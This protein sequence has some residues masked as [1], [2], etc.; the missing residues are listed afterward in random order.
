MSLHGE[1]GAAWRRRQRDMS[2]RASQWP[3]PQ[4]PTTA[5]T[6]WRLAR[7][8]TPYGDRRRTW[9]AERWR[10]ASCATRRGARSLLHQGRGLHFWLRCGGRR[11]SGG[12]RGSATSW[13]STPWCRWRNSWWKSFR[14]LWSTSHPR[15]PCLGRQRQW[16]SLLH[17]FQQWF[18]A[19][20]PTVEYLAPAPAVSESPAPVVE[21]ISPASAGLFP[22][23]AVESIAPAPAIV[24]SPAPVEEYSSPVPALFQASAPVMEYSSPALLVFPSPAPIA[25]FFSP[26][27]VVPAVPDVEQDTVED[28]E[29]EEYDQ[30]VV[31]T[32]VVR[33]SHK[34]Q[35]QGEGTFRLRNSKGSS[36]S[37]RTSS[38][39]RTTTSLDSCFDLVRADGATPS[40]L[41]G[42]AT[43]AMRCGSRRRSLLASFMKSGTPHDVSSISS[44]GLCLFYVRLYWHAFVFQANLVDLVLLLLFVGLKRTWDAAFPSSMT[45]P[46]CSSS[47]PVCTRMTVMPLPIVVSSMACK[48]LVL[49][50]FQAKKLG[51]SAGMDQKDFMLP[52]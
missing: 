36:S 28:E 48:R 17:T 14:C 33:V 41:V 40:M 20:V 12:T 5:S 46:G 15:L 49:L 22:A 45:G 13:C 3:C 37:G 27:P 50:G 7:S 47:W 9:P 30:P 38:C 31:S 23:P 52:A 11:G 25:E 29:E 26:T 51:I 10:S 18:Q 35:S 2:S 6:R 16:W 21:Y 42:Q 19:P 8:P 4:P 43:T 44:L 32:L 1:H 34:W 24:F 39:W